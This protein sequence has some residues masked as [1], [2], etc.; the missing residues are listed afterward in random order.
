MIEAVGKSWRNPNLCEVC[1]FFQACNN[2]ERCLKK[3]K[4]KKRLKK[5]CYN[6][7]LRKSGKGTVVY[8]SLW[9]SSCAAA[10]GRGRLVLE[11]E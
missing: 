10:S 11:T 8:L 1:F 3:K 5:S 7:G 2:R 6:L 4:K 9:G